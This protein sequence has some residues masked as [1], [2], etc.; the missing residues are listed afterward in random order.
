MQEQQRESATYTKEQIG[1]MS[2]EQLA[3][4][5]IEDLVDLSEQDREVALFFIQKAKMDVLDARIREEMGA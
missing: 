2:D 3:I 5:K 1:A 4:L